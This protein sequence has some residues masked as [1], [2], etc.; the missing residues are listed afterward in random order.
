MAFSHRLFPVLAAALLYGFAFAIIQPLLN[1]MQIDVMPASRKGLAGAVYFFALDTGF[2][3]GSAGF[4]L[5]L[6]VT[7]FIPVFILCSIIVFS[8]IFLFKMIDTRNRKE[9]GKD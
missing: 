1:F 5:L 3:S 7:G 9:G 8:S 2:S 6:E 4:G